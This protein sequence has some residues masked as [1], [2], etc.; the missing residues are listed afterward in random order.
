MVNNRKNSSTAKVGEHIICRC[1][2]SI[3]WGLNHIENKHTLYRGKDCIK[4]VLHFFKRTRKKY[5]SF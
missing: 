1:S 4:K 5:N 2:M 3:I